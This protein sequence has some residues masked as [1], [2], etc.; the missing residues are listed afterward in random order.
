[1]EVKAAFMGAPAE[2][3]TLLGYVPEL[4]AARATVWLLQSMNAGKRRLS[5][6]SSSSSSREASSI[7]NMPLQPASA[8]GTAGKLHPQLHPRLQHSSSSGGDGGGGSRTL[9]SIIGRDD[10]VEVSGPV[11]WPYS[12][13]GQFSFKNGSCTGVM[14]GPRAV[15]TAGHCVYSREKKMWQEDL[16][17]VPFRWAAVREHALFAR[18]L[19]CS[20]SASLLG[21][22][23]FK[24]AWQNACSENGSQ[25]LLQ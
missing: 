13:V 4:S 21:S 5:G 25:S 10:R 20:C 7:S 18:C 3:Q 19:P 23:I 22:S 15:L 2:G 1:M 12:A 17:F 9:R 16:K 24:A 14:I 6:S 11:G 8:D